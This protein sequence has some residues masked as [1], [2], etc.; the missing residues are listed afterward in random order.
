MSKI[1]EKL[2]AYL[3]ERKEID[4]KKAERY[5]DEASKAAKKLKNSMPLEDIM[6]YQL[7]FDN[8][9]NNLNEVREALNLRMRR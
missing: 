6:D 5:L 2:D 3:N 4:L 7:A 9:E 8:I 1:E